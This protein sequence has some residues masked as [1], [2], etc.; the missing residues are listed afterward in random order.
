[1]TIARRP[2]NPD[3]E[4]FLRRLITETVAGELD[5]YAWPRLMREHLLDIQYQSKRASAKTLF[6]DGLSQ[7]ILVDGEDAGWLFIADLED[8]IRIVEIML[9]GAY[10]R[11]GVGSAVI[12]DI[13]AAAGHAGK[14]VR[15]G[16]N[17]VNHGAIRLYGRLG[18][19]HTGGDE[20]QCQMECTPT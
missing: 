4:P 17:A 10:R 14:P 2:E 11:K 18:F 5:T 6:P 3:D 12:G 7:I 13:L 19:R 9:L 8:Q 1:M 15:L 16:V 20:V